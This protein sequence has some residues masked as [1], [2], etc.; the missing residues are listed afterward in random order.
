LQ[1]NFF[2]RIHQLI[3]TEREIYIYAKYL[4]HIVAD[5]TSLSKINKFNE[6]FSNKDGRSAEP[7]KKGQAK[8]FKRTNKKVKTTEREQKAWK[9]QNRGRLV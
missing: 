7:R 1:K 3:S 6:Y 2:S 4:Q 8:R 5:T 9:N